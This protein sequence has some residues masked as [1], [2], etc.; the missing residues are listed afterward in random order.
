M[1]FTE[2]IPR[3]IEG[4]ENYCAQYRITESRFGRDCLKDPNLLNDL[5]NGRAPNVRTL[6]KI[7]AF[8]KKV[9]K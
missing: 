5:R 1:D 4:A 2:A 9:R 6:M 8:L 3:I 7:E